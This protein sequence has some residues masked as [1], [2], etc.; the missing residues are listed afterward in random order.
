MPSNV[1]HSVTKLF[2]GISSRE[3]YRVRKFLTDNLHA[4]QRV[5]TVIVSRLKRWMGYV[6]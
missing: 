6:A 4:P 1:T 2:E 3:K 5:V